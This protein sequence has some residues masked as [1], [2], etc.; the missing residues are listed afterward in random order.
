MKKLFVFLFF[1][2][3]IF[4][5][6]TL[7]IFRHNSNWVIEIRDSVLQTQS[8]RNASYVSVPD[9]TVSLS[10]RRSHFCRAGF[11]L[12][13]NKQNHKQL[14]QDK[15]IQFIQGSIID[16]VSSYSLQHLLTHEGK[17]RLKRHIRTNINKNFSE[18]VIEDVYFRNFILE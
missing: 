18:P 1:L 13:I 3:L 9:V 14:T 2:T 17:M 16:I 10:G 11:T 7:Y 6:F 12:H 15:F 8:D 5:L 4:F